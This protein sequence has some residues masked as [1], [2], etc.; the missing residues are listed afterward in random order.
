MSKSSVLFLVWLS[1]L[2]TQVSL[3]Q[4]QPYIYGDVILKNRET[5][6]GLIRWGQGQVF[7]T[8]VLNVAKPGKDKLAYLSHEQ[9]NRLSDNEESKEI[10]WTFMSLWQDKVPKR[11]VEVLCRFGD[12]GNI[13]FTGTDKAQVHLK[14]GTKLRV[15]T[16]PGSGFLG[17]S[18]AVYAG[19]RSK[20]IKREEISWVRFKECPVNTA[21]RPGKLLYGTV[22]TTHGPFTGFVQWD[23][24]YLTA[25][26]IS[27]MKQ[28]GKFASYSFKDINLI[29]KRG[30]F[31]F[32]KLKSGQGVL[33][34]ETNDGT[35]F[36]RSV[37]VAHPTYGKRKV[38]WKAFKSF[39][40][41][42]KQPYPN[43]AYSTYTSPRRI[44][45]AVKTKDNKV[46]KGNCTFD[47]DEEWTIE[48]LEGRK[49]GIHYQVPFHNISS[50]VP[51]KTWYSLV[52]FRDNSTFLMGW[53]NDVS[54]KNWGTIIW[55]ANRQYRYFPW[56]QISSITFRP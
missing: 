14:N 17:K 11:K 10:D 42:D 26:K 12:I 35:S 13:H 54:D 9:I 52:T 47:L 20:V 25:D 36:K 23:D 44:Y 49:D 5:I 40:V 34:S 1:L 45:A 2:F 50:I 31:A 28:D 27:G 6:T 55:S 30:N 37:L 18:L 39:E 32:L 53:E 24:R 19:A 43:A 7:W 8:D 15:E 46:Y 3:A 33:L 21:Y 16:G 51:Y 48:M 22:I 38:E 4:L 29:E 56:E 41:R